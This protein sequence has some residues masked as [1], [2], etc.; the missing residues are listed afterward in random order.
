VRGF[1]DICTTVIT[2]WGGAIINFVGDEI[3]ASFG[4]P[5]GYEDDA[6]RAVHAGLDLVANVGEIRSQ[7]GEPLEVRIAIAT[8]LVLIGENQSVIGEAVVT[9]AGLRNIAPPN[10]VIIT[11]NTRKLLSSVFVLEGVSRPMTAYRVTGKRTVESR[12][13]ATRG[14]GKPT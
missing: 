14:T 5:K 2:R 3:L 8:G 4:H 1:Q 6:E 11:E 9:A 10:S 12:F 7:S 13:A